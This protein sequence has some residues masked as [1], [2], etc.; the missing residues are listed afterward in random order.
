M[1]ITM[2]MKLDSPPKLVE[3]VKEV[4]GSRDEM[5]EKVVKVVEEYVRHGVRAAP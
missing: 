3:R 1:Q 4:G 2:E 5:V